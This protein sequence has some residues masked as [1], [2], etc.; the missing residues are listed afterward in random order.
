MS[1]PPLA[2]RKLLGHRL[3]GE[4]H[5]GDNVIDAHATY[6]LGVTRPD[7][8]KETVVVSCGKCNKALQI[9]VLSAVH[10]LAGYFHYS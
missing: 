5:K 8:G 7:R 10:C 1:T 9:R 2:P 3:A 6:P 4:S